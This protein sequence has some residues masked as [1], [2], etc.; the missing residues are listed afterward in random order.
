MCINKPTNHHNS[1]GRDQMATGVKASK[2][3]AKK[4]AKK[5]TKKVVKK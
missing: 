1:M 3:A 5:A 4:T 2:K